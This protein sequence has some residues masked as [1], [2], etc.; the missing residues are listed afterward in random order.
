LHFQAR[1]GRGARGS[2]ARPPPPGRLTSGDGGHERPVAGREHSSG[3]SQARRDTGAQ[4]EVQEHV[5]ALT[6]PDELFGAG[7]H[8]AAMWTSSPTAP[9]LHSVAPLHAV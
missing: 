8:L 1:A 5:K 3:E 4:L 9:T 2:A 7:A 6:A